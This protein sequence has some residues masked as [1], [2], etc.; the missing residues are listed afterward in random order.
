VKELLLFQAIY[1]YSTALWPLLDMN[2]FMEISGPKN[3][4]W[5][6]KTVSVVLLAVSNAILAAVYLQNISVP[7][8][9]L[10]ISCCIGLLVID[11]YYVR[12]KVIL[13]VYLADATIEF[14]LL[15]GWVFI[16]SDL[17]CVA[18]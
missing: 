7:V 2:S 8:I 17:F 15:T 16:F 3:D 9:I 13:R 5:L 1:Y 4:K 11:I 12:M 14:F 6:V 10:S 18:Y